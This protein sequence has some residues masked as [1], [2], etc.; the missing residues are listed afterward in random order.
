MHTNIN[1]NKQANAH[2][3]QTKQILTKKILQKLSLSL[4]HFGQLLAMG[5]ALKCG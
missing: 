3:P 5:P 2:F 4:F 1:Q